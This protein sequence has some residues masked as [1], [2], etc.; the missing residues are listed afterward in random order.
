MKNLTIK[1]SSSIKEA[2]LMLN[3]TA[4]KC[5]LVVDDELRLLGTLTD[6]D[7]R[8]SILNSVTINSSIKDSYNDKPITLRS[9]K[10]SKKEAR[11]IMV[12]EK[13]SL[14]PIVD[15][16]NMITDYI[17]RDK[18]FISDK[19]KKTNKI[20]SSIVIMAGG[21]G[22]RLEPFTKVLPK[23]LVPIHNKPIIQ[24]IIER[25]TKFGMNEFWLTVNYKSLILKAYFSEMDKEYSIKFIDENEPLGTAGSLKYFEDKFNQ[26]FIVTN[27]DIIVDVNYPD[28]Y[29]FHIKNGYDITLIA[30]VKEYVIPYGTC[31][32][33]KKGHLK[34][35][36]EKPAF[37]FLVNTGVY[38][39]NPEVLQFIP[40]NKMY[41]FTTLIED[42]KKAGMNIGVFPV[43]ED[44][45]VDIGQWSDYKKAIEQL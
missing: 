32:L 16:M 36:K 38:M 11:D 28:F 14:I 31:E 12:K 19:S 13:I 45:W 17:T 37:E 4:E 25:F 40:E 41:H 18:L 8:R 42:A 35:I 43:S 15:K 30:S 6:G 26:P 5:L 27:C 20:N 33:N 2:M 29:Q 10:Y 24:H 9:G 7:I 21:K 34:K 1:N 3:H 39:L 22:T 23:P 44:A